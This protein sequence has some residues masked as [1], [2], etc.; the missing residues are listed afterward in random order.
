MPLRIH[1]PDHIPLP[2]ALRNLRRKS[3]LTLTEVAERMGKKREAFTQLSRWELGK[4]L[5][6]IDQLLRYL[7]AVNATLSDLDY[8]L[9][10]IRTSP[11]LKEIAD[12]LDSLAREA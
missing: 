12:E 2:D 7:A 11:R 6:R 9:H 5:P 1:Q 8:E 10:P 3:S 4:S